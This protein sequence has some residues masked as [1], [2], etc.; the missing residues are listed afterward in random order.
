MS[1]QRARVRKKGSA[2]ARSR[3]RK[4][5]T[6]LKMVAVGVFSLLLPTLLKGNM[7]APIFAQ[8]QPL[9]GLILVLGCFLYWFFEE[10]KPDVE[11]RL[12]AVLTPDP[13]QQTEA[14]LAAEAKPLANAGD[15]LAPRLVLP[16]LPE[17]TVVELARAQSVVQLPESETLRA[18]WSNEIFEVIEWRRFEAVVE[19]LFQHLGF[20]TKTQTHGADGGVDI[21]LYSR[22]QAGLLISLVQCKHWHKQRVGVA[23]VR[24]LRGVMAA[25]NL[26]LGQFASSSGFT[27]DAQ[28]FAEESGITLMDGAA[29]LKRIVSCTPEQQTDLLQVALEGEYWR[30]TCANCG[31]KLVERKSRHDGGKFWGCPTFPRCKTTIPMRTQTAHKSVGMNWRL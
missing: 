14:L 25:H 19:R 16:E 1:K 29:L 6:A 5:E 4:Q 24:E 22:A 30:P 7:L 18:T 12:G 31:I 28:I 20:D 13:A 2:E 9:A 23:K 27:A 17:R 15:A 26:K 21:W 8:L 10:K 11:S 3:Q